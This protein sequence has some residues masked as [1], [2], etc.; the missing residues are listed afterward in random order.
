MISIHGLRGYPM[1]KE[2]PL[3]SRQKAGLAKMGIGALSIYGGIFSGNFG[4][5]VGGGMLGLEG[6]YTFFTD[7]DIALPPTNF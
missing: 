3:T 7:R 2:D 5:I 4:L 1:P 6:A